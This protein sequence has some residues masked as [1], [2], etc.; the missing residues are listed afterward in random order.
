VEA[1]IRNQVA[2]EALADERWRQTLAS[3]TEV[4]QEVDLAKP[5]ETNSG[6]YWYNLHL[7]LVAAERYRSSEPA[8]LAKIRDTS[9][10]ICAKKQYLASAL[11][12]LPDHLHLAL[13]GALEQAPEEIALAF[14]NNLA[15]VL[16]RRS[17]WMPG[18]YAGTFGDGGSQNM[19][20]ASSPGR[21]AG[22]GPTP[23]H[24]RLC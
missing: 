10:R 4:N 24:G 12:V 14:L 9:L 7:V 13:R 8:T 22:R 2:N 15:H 11:A 21:R 17:W 23:G 1:Y 20:L 16:D 18:Y 19:T 5:T 3:F 6:R